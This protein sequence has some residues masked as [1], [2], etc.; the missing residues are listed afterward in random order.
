M[1]P[2]FLT[3]AEAKI[4]VASRSILKSTELFFV[5][6]GGPVIRISVLPKFRLRKFEC[7]HSFNS[8]TQEESEDFTCSESG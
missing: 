2:T 6:D 7:S 4:I 1:I 3:V 8:L 5:R